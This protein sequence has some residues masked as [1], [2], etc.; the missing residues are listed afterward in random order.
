MDYENLVTANPL[1][2]PLYAC[3]KATVTPTHEICPTDPLTPPSSDFHVENSKFNPIFADTNDVDEFVN[4]DEAP[5][6][7][8]PLNDPL[9]FPVVQN[10]SVIVVSSRGKEKTCI[11]VGNLKTKGKPS[12]PI[13]KPT[14]VPPGPKSTSIHVGRSF[15]VSARSSQAPKNQTSATL[16][17]MKHTALEHPMSSAPTVVLA[18]RIAKLLIGT[19]V[20]LSHAPTHHGLSNTQTSVA[21]V[22]A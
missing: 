14:V 19:V 4:L 9:E 16:N 12:F 8:L 11:S 2:L 21:Y 18:P 5:T 22:V 7:T 13:C 1:P 17:P 10:G 15:N 3:V 20:V 6:T